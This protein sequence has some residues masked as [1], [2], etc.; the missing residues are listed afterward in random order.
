MA[1]ELEPYQVILRSARHR[2]GDAPVRASSPVPVSSRDV[3]Y[4]ADIRKAVETL[5]NVRV[6]DLSA[7]RY[8]KGKPRRFKM[9][10]V[11]HRRV[12]EGNCQAARGRSHRVLLVCPLTDSQTPDQVLQL[13]VSL[14]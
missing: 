14:H 5:W 10:L 3:R 7:L 11:T 4:Q 12:E 2:E 1:I 8:Y 9:R 6:E 13:K